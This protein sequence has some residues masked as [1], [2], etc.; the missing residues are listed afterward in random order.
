VDTKPKT[1]EGKF[2]HKATWQIMAADTNIR[3]SDKEWV[4][5]TWTQ[6]ASGARKA[7]GPGK[8]GSTVKG[9]VEA[10]AGMESH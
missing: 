8:T 2:S 4:K 6:V 7:G 1:G 9:S 10:P 3:E 5:L